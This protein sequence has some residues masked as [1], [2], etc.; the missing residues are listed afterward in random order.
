M[1]IITAEATVV[2][3]SDAILIVALKIITAAEIQR[4]V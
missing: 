4:I 2:T 3:A 1:K